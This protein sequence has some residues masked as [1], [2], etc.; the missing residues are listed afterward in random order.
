MSSPAAVFS[1]FSWEPQPE[2]QKLVNALVAEALSASPRTQALADRM[3]DQTATRFVDWLD[4]IAVPTSRGIAGELARVGFSAQPLPGAAGCHVHH[5]GLFPAVLLEEGSSL[6][7]GIKV[8]RVAD[9]LAAQQV[10]AHGASAIQGLPLTPLRMVR[11]WAE[12]GAELWAVE[13]HGTR[14]FALERND[15][16]AA[17]E[18]LTHLERFR[19]RRRLFDNDADGFAEM[20]RLI[21]AA[22]AGLGQHG[23][24]DA[25]FAAER[26]YWQRRNRAARIQKSR[27]DALGL[28][29][30]NHDHH[31]YR[32][33][34]AFFHHTIAVFEKLGYHCRERFY[35]GL[36]AGWGAQVLEQPTTGMVIFCDVDMSPEELQGD[37]SHQGL[38]P[39]RDKLGTIGLWA[40]L[41]GEAILGAG[42]HHLECMFDHHALVKQLESEANIKTM[43]PFTTFPFLR[44]AFTEGER[45]PVSRERAERLVGQGLLTR[46]QA[47]T[48]IR[49][50]AIGSH[51][52]NLERND[53]YKGFNQKGVSDIIARTDP[54]RMVTAGA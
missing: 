46:E 22:I 51:L 16:K 2:A 36:E 40:A 54:R 44:Q 27:Q 20:H 35:A 6:R 42:M 49:G 33:S 52:E 38:P 24:C 13:R 17:A 47:E 8:E 45:W 11:A 34:R 18:Y 37:F 14:S 28:G 9:F 30:A 15:A 19:T 43:D 25:F 53:G 7:L 32:S 12:Q 10:P 41:H 26:D 5:G 39:A 21:D 31:T 48:F 1:Q 29:W 3:R 23:A 50:G 4:F